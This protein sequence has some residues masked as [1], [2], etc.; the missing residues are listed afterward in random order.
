MGVGARAVA[1]FAGSRERVPSRAG[2]AQPVLLQCAWGIISWVLHHGFRD[3]FVRAQAGEQCGK[4]LAL[5]LAEGPAAS[6][7]GYPAPH[8]ELRRYGSH[9]R[10][11]AGH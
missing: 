11:Q 4:Q 10:I 8:P 9:V 1:H 5:V 3:A 2:V 7:G 6:R